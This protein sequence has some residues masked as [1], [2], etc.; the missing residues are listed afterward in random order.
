M[1]ELCEF[2]QVC[3]VDQKSFKA[4][5]SRW[6][7]A[8]TQLASFT[9]PTIYRLLL[10]SAKAAAAQCTGGPSGTKC[11]VKWGNN[12]TWDGTDG[13]GQQMSALEV[14]IGSLIRQDNTQKAKPPVTFDTGGTSEPKPDAGHDFVEDADPYHETPATRSDKIGAWFLT[15]FIVCMSIFSMHFM[16]TTVWENIPPLVPA[17]AIKNGEKIPEVLDLKGKGR[18]VD[19]GSTATP[20]LTSIGEES[21]AMPK[22]RG[23]TMTT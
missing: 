11:G 7:T 3:N 18:V 17:T 9:Y 12:G 23:G 19:R 8:T 1:T 14:T 22:Y 10:T 20:V 21:V 5:L 15:A 6:M 16:W 13:V 2:Y 4:Y